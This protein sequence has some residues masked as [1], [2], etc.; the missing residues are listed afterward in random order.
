MVYIGYGIALPVLPFFLETRVGGVE[1]FSVSW[2]T[3]MVT[4]IFMFTLFAF[5]PL[6]GRLSDRIGRRPVIL[7]GLGGC[8][9]ALVSFA[10]VKN[11]WLGYLARALGGA[12]VSAVLPVALAYI[13]DISSR[14]T[15]AHHF[16]RISA[17]GT[18]GFLVGPVIG[19]WLSGITLSTNIAGVDSMSFP[20]LVSA[21]A[22]SLVWIAVYLWLPEPSVSSQ[23]VPIAADSR[24]SLVG[25]TN[26]LLVLAL[27]GMFG[28]GSFE[29][30]IALQSQQALNLNPFQIG[31][32]FMECSLMMV[33]GQVLLF[34][35]LV[36]HFSFRLV[37]IPAMLLMA[38]GL[39][40]F[41]IASHFT[42][43]ILAVGL[44]GIGSGVLIPILAYQSSLHANRSQGAVLGKQTAAV[45]LGQGLGSAAAGGLFAIASQ[46][47]FWS[48]AGLL[49]VGALLGLRVGRV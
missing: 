13:G 42:L 25:P 46:A 35:R 16:A 4:G 17:A 28:L 43:I 14:T 34:A 30:A 48:S 31:L 18:L 33:V 44:V 1:G 20:F 41:P 22:G 8:V 6:W 21:A 49:V 27:F 9:V 39:A 26:S 40:L 47:P 32:L 37:V 5:A 19:G 29:V 3:G 10:I 24:N 11:L 12:M 45:S 36:R 7:I 23:T 15:R 38:V 2:H